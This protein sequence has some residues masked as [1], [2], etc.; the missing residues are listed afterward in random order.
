MTTKNPP[1]PYD[2][3]SINAIVGRAMALH[4]GG[5]LAEAERL[6]KSALALNPDHFEALHFFG[7]LEAQR[8][9]NVEADEFMRRSLEINSGVAEAFTNHARVLNALKRSE[10]A[11]AACDKALSLNGRSVEAIVS[12]GIALYDLGRYHDALS[13]YDQAL[14]IKP[15]YIVALRNRANAL[16]V[17]RRSDEALAIC[18]QILAVNSKDSTSLYCRANALFELSR[19]AESLLAYDRARAVAPEHAEACNVA[20]AAQATCD[21]VRIARL[22][23]ELSARIEG[24]MPFSPFSLLG[25]CDDPALHAKCAKNYIADRTKFLSRSGYARP[26]AP[27]DKIR[28]AY[29]SSDF[30]EH[31][32]AYLIAGLIERHDRTRFDIIGISFGADDGGNMRRRLVDAFRQ[33][34]DVRTL[35]NPAAEALLNGLDIDIAV[36]LHGYTRGSR[37]ELLCGRIAPIQVNYL[38]Y[39]GTMGADF[40][41]Y[42]V[43]DAVTVPFDQQP[44]YT[45]KI[46]HMPICYQVNDDRRVV[47]D[48][49]PTR[50]DAGLPEQGFVFCS[51]N[52]VYKITL[53]FFNVWMHLL[54]AVPGSVLWLLGDSPTLMSNLRREAQARKVDPTRLIFAG[55]A[56]LAEHLARHRLADLFLDTLPYNAH[57]TASDALWAGLPVLTCRGRAFAGRVAASL[58]HAV[59]LPELV[60]D[61]LAAYEAMALRLVTEQAQLAAIRAKL[62]RNRLTYPLFDTDL[63]RRH[64]EAA[65]TRMWDIWQRGE[66][67]QS[68]SVE[69]IKPA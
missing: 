39:P 32:T 4:R 12:R 23:E 63:F 8:G 35:S 24:G 10:Q 54:N 11:I 52:N 66:S 53:P 41:D 69:A 26:V 47:A 2:S 25:I 16:I 5:Q 31:A 60:T 9:H 58:L 27:R 62:A 51:F 68:F 29:F 40:I 22:T 43:A 38:G 44:F 67:P 1:N 18:D 42:V 49:T 19:F 20:D 3:N 45:E 34:H 13:T 61:S 36:D 37:P 21:W 14:A 6:Y 46:V 57:T 17:L 55:R 28:I 56:P 15:D 48:Q 33:F 65:Y 7:L 59:G 64:I 30:R 50:R